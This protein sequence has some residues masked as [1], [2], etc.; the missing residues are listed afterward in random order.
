MKNKFKKISEKGFS[1]I[2]LTFSMF[3]FMLITGSLFG[4]LELG[5]SDRNRAGRQT[6]SLKNAR[7]ATYLIGRDLMNA[8]L[9]F[10]K[11]GA[12][13]PDGGLN[14][15]LQVPL[16]GDGKRD[17]LTSISVGNNVNA[18]TLDISRPNDAISIIYRNFDFNNGS[19]IKVIDELS[20]SANRVVLKTVTGGA[21]AVRVHDVFLAE[22]DFTQVLVMVTAVDISSDTITFQYGDPLSI[23]QNRS[24]SANSLHNSLLRK[25]SSTSDTTCTEYNAIL[26]V[27]V[28]LKKVVWSSYKIDSTGTL[29]R[30]VY[31]NN[32]GE[33]AANQIQVQPLI[34]NV[35]SMQ[36][37]Y[38]MKDAPDTV[39]PAAG[40]DGIRGNIDDDQ[41]RMNFIRQATLSLEIEA[42][43]KD[44]T[45]GAKQVVKL[46]TTFSTRN[47]QYDD[48]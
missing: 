11:T 8:G 1:L 35:R 25:C 4:L 16:D 26:E 27:G 29:S 15:K 40:L 34:Y 17:V 22:N 31:G 28:R 30:F 19:P 14:T 39:D 33:T 5:R 20:T 12:L 47:L 41:D 43:Q 9:G 37:D 13:I 48:R 18:N 38:S 3:L 32:T 36:L 2:E 6:D 44:E 23:N 10:H 45:A 46:N 7:V 21:A 24:G 42:A